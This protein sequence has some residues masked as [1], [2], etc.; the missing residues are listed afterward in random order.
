VRLPLF[1][2][3]ADVFRTDVRCGFELAALLGDHDFSVRIQNR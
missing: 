2:E 3:S 1:E